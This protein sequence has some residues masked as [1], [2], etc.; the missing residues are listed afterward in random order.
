MKIG[1]RGFLKYSGGGLAGISLAS[2]L[3]YSACGVSSQGNDDQ[4]LFIGDEIAVAET[5]SGKVRGYIL[6]DVYY[7]LGIPYGAD[8]SGVNRFM[9]PR[10]PEPWTDVFPAIWWGNAAPQ[11]IEG[12]YSGENRYR[13]FRHHANFDDISEN[14]LSV[15][16]F[17]PGYND[18]KKRP[19]LVWMHGGSWNYGISIEHDGVNGEN[20]ARHGDI[21]FCSI[22]HRLGPMGFS[23]LSAAGDERFAASGNAG[24]LD[25]VAALEWVH[26]NIEN[27]GGDPGNVTIIGQSGGGG[28]IITTLGMPS[29][30]GLFHKAVALSPASMEFRDREMKMKVGEYI[31]RE[32]GLKPGQAD[33]LQQL[34]WRDYYAVALRA[35]EKY[36]KDSGIQSVTP[37]QIFQPQV[38]GNFIPQHPVNPVASPYGADIP[39]ILSSTTNENSNA[40][41]D[42]SLENI[43]FEGVKDEM[44][45]VY[46]DKAGE[47]VDAYARA[48]PDRK[49][50]EIWSMANRFRQGSVVIAD[51]KS[52]QAAPVYLA[53]FGWHPPL[54]DN[55]MRAFHCIDQC[56]WFYNTDVMLTHTGGGARPRA[57]SEK[58]AN[59]LLRFM[60]TGDPNGGGLPEWPAYTSAKGEMMFL[61]DVP[62]VQFD[63]DREA[64][65]TLPPY[66]L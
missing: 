24:A 59:S 34:G 12:I 26:D 61:D 25:L 55:R 40:F 35:A 57:L 36:I 21:V 65:K 20:L 38:D 2:P 4:V 47:I 14:C 30:K 9:P 3:A 11:L 6:R 66:F 15:N 29:A 17:T 63:P 56:F 46:G 43:S 7:F 13:A 64:R 44:A 53:W 62:Q 54:F 60:N 8:T 50:V 33:G 18:G 51:A 48:F 19:V 42:S 41:R 49:P 28:K 5:T 45:K 27:F 52:K 1:R 22:N 39:L 37:V 58:M 10:K 16:V 23:D 32:A 31:L